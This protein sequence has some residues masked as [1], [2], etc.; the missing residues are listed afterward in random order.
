MVNVKNKII[1]CAIENESSYEVKTKTKV[2]SE[3]TTLIAPLPSLKTLAP[4]K[5]ES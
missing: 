1:S 2:I 3:A 4:H 5:E